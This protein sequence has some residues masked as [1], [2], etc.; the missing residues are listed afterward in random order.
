VASEIRSAAVAIAEA[1]PQPTPVLPASSVTVVLP[2]ARP[3][4]RLTG[5]EITSA[6]VSIAEAETVFVRPASAITVDLPP[7]RR[8]E[9]LAA[10][11][12][13]SAAVS[14]AAPEREAPAIAENATVSLPP[15]QP[16][17]RQPAVPRAPAQPLLAPETTSPR[18]VRLSRGE[19]A[20]VT[21]DAPVWKPQMASNER[22]TVTWIPLQNAAHPNIQ[23]LNA[24]RREGVAAKA[25]TVL[26]DRG[27]RRIAV[28]DAPAVKEESVVLYPA[29]HRRLG[30]S[31]AAQF[32]CRA[33]E[34]SHVAMLTVFIGRD[35]ALKAASHEG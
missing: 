15:P 22:T 28:G 20:L 16:E 8:T 31:L 2:P 4:A 12:L 7:A 19:V 10:G 23:I 29:S 33:I 11:E 24:A 5:A 9:H 25:R 30:K 27:W 3:I 6:D 34:S 35:A 1:D 17:P 26:L 14:V 21:T 32:G 18:L 13:R